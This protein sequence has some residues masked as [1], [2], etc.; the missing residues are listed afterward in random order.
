MDTLTFVRLAIL[1]IC[2]EYEVYTILFF[3]CS[4]IVHLLLFL[5]SS[6]FRSVS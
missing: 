3:Y 1:S 4:V 2:Y 5:P 6:L